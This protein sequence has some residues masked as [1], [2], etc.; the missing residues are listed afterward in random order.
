[1]VFRFSNNII[2]PLWNRN[3]VDHVQ[4]TAAEIVGVEHRGGFYETAGALAR[5]GPQP[6]VP[7]AHHD[8]DGATNLLRRRR[9]PQQTSRSPPRHPAAHAPKMFLP[10]PSVASMAQA[11]STA[12]A[13][14]L[15]QRTRRCPRVQ[16]RNLCR[17]ETADR[18][19]ALGRRS[20]LSPHRQAP[21][22]PAPR[23]SSSSF[24]APL[25]SCFAIPP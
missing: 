25:S 17:P 10:T 13:C 11:P 3:Y 22:A 14:P 1:M 23:K 5:H 18:Q 4:I 7:T 20:L 19:L 16:H 12:S 9:S 2:E 6:F 8:R 24:A 15:P 21:R